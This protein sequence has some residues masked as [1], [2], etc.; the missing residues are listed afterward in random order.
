MTLK[1]YIKS[2]TIFLQVKFKLL[3]V[4]VFAII[5]V[6]GYA[7]LSGTYYI[8]A[9]N[10]NDAAT[11]KTEASAWKSFSK[12]NPNLLSAG[13]KILLKRGEVW[14]QR[15]EIKGAG[16]ATNWISVGAYGNG[17][18]KPKISLTNSKDDIA[19][20]ICD[21]DKSAGFARSQNIS[22]IQIQ[23]L[24]IANTRMGIY[25][26]SIMGSV[27]TGFK[28]IN[29][30]FNNINCDEVMLA[31][32]AGTDRNAKHVEISNQLKALK[33]N[34]ATASS[35]NGGGS[36][37]YIFPAAIFI[38][39]QTFA[40]QTVS[41]NHTTVLSEFEVFNCSFN[42]VCA[43][44]ST[45]FYFPLVG[46]NNG[47][48][49]WRQLVH[50]VKIADCVSVGT[51][52]GAISFDGVNGGAVPDANGVMQPDAN[53]WGL[54]KNFRVT[55]GSIV[56]GRSW[57]DGTTGVM[58]SNT[59]NFL[60]DKCEF[61][62]IINQGNPDGCG[63]DFETN[64][65]QVTL[66]NSKFFNNDGHAI[67]M[68]NGGSYGGCTHIKIQKNLFAKNVKSSPSLNELELSN[69][70]DG[71][72]DIVVRN[73]IAFLRKTN[74]DN[75][76]ISF[77]NTNRTYVTATDNDI[78]QLDETAQ[79]ITV[80]FLGETYTF[81]ATVS[82]VAIPVVSALSVNDGIAFAEKPAIVINSEISKTSPVS[83][84]VSENSNFSGANWEVYNSA[85]NFNLSPTDGLKTI[86]FKVKN[87]M[88]E[89]T[90]AIIKV[91]L[92]TV[93]DKLEAN[94]RSHVSAQ[95][96]PNPVK[97]NVKVS[98]FKILPNS[99][100]KVAADDDVYQ[101]ALL[102]LAGSILE[103]YQYVGNDFSLDMNQYQNG[104]YF[105]KMIGT[106]NSFTRTIVKN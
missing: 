83:Y 3:L 38:G 49:V 93:P 51:V 4:F 94:T 55:M 20:L 84:M 14:N 32:N 89:S 98:F 71:H 25:Y 11:G 8:D 69:S 16:T 34:L 68:M 102:S 92:K 106:K 33:G 60:I 85:I 86:Y 42:D 6:S 87:V 10:G 99:E 26:R 1:P 23:D 27:N 17:D 44:I 35:T 29:C 45:S 5:S 91:S 59:Q 79:A 54:I 57:P 81:H 76:S 58:F 61:S 95:L 100:S 66:Q 12:I 72:S 96:A 97:A 104:I 46:N 21:L 18:V 101:V 37:E 65:N 88:G 41:G 53:G 22:Y 82:T 70:I 47:S 75:L 2:N 105:L 40:P 39:G 7:A 74:K 56:T 52:S 73:N 19:I 50:K 64:D 28:V 31:C 43:S 103:Q 24:G 78:Y 63:F 62:D 13:T 15:L 67:L 36:Y 80:S 48:N 9:S 77:Y 30:T 90:T